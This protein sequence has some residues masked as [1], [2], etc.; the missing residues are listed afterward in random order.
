MVE[1]VCAS[2]IPP[3][4][5]QQALADLHGKLSHDPT[6]IEAFTDDPNTIW[7]VAIE[8]ATAIGSLF[9]YALRRPETTRPKFFLYEIDV[10][11]SHQ[12]QGIGRRLVEAFLKEAKSRSAIGVWVQAKSTDANAEAF[13][14]ACGGKREEDGDLLFSF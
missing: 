13:Y 8:G 1:I 4:V 3:N 14:K 5:L 9:G 7:L 6:A 12:R 2:S 11:E 10:A